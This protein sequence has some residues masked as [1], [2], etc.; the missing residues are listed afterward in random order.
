MK[1]RVSGRR[2]LPANL[3]AGQAV[4]ALGKGARGWIASWGLRRGMGASWRLG[5]IVGSTSAAPP[6]SPGGGA[7]ED[8][9][10]AFLWVGASLA[11]RRRRPL[12]VRRAHR[13]LG[14]GASVLPLHGRA[15]AFLDVCSLPGGV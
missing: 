3:L 14:S 5:H 13:T 2:L 4:G 9:R 11:V 10:G 7:R 15:W 12:G 8:F 6:F 1:R